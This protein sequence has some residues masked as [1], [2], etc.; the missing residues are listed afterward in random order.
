ME[1]LTCSSSRRDHEIPYGSRSWKSF[2]GK[3]ITHHVRRKNLRSRS[4]RWYKRIIELPRRITQQWN[5]Q[6][7][8]AT[9]AEHVAFE[10][11]STREIPILFFRS[12]RASNTC[13]VSLPIKSIN[14][15]GTT[16]T[17]MTAQ[18]SVYHDWNEGSCL[19]QYGIT[20]SKFETFLARQRPAL[21]CQ[22]F[23]CMDKIVHPLL[24][25]NGAIAASVACSCSSELLFN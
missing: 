14:F 4:L 18:A 6:V 11:S 19:A 2:R 23:E 21:Q 9:P 13:S 12:N 22:L 10:I 1:P 17:H 8:C 25:S 3:C 5:D 7:S 24:T 16:E 15:P 20:S